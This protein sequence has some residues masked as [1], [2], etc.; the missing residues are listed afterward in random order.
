MDGSSTDVNKHQSRSVTHVTQLNDD[1]L[2]KIMDNLNALDLCAIK[3]TCQRFRNLST[4]YFELTYKDSFSFGKNLCRREQ[5]SECD[6]TRILS[7]FGQY[8]TKLILDATNME[9]DVDILHIIGK[10]QN[11]KELELYQIFINTEGINEGN[12]LFSDLERLSIDYCFIED[13]SIYDLLWNCKMLKHLEIN[14]VEEIDGNFLAKKFG[15][16]ESLSLIDIKCFERC[17]INQCLKEH[18]NLKK[19]E[20]IKCNFTNDFM[21]RVIS[22]NSVNIEEISIQLRKFTDSFQANASTLLK[23]NQLKRLEFNCGQKPIAEF[24]T[25]LANNANSSLEHLSISDTELNQ[26]LCDALIKLRNLKT[27]KL[28]SMQ[29]TSKNFPKFLQQNFE[30]LEQLFIVDFATFNAQTVFEIVSNAGNLKKLFIKE[31]RQ[32]TGF[33][34]KEFAHLLVCRKKCYNGSDLIVYMEKAA[35]KTTKAI[36]SKEILENGATYIKLRSTSDDG[37]QNERIISDKGKNDGY[38]SYEF[39]STSGDEDDYMQYDSNDD[40]NAGMFDSDSEVVDDDD[41]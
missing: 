29:K 5:M 39:E 23:L 14:D 3:D 30:H 13:D 21:F 32:F 4:Y 6:A 12:G 15:Q 10:Y 36:I 31:C 41:D 28:I 1:C 27:L 8:I 26:D 35:L 18:V 7:H 40:D 19:V 22:D 24:I 9:D 20:M 11:I 2:L 38:D 16:L 33:D 34:R 37:I 17:Y 25:A